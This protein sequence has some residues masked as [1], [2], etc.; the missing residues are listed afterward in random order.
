LEKRREGSYPKSSP[1]G[2]KDEVRHKNLFFKG[3]ECGEKE[4]DPYYLINHLES[5]LPGPRGNIL[6]THARVIGKE[7][8]KAGLISNARRKVNHA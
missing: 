5:S 2:K 3:R 4:E 1:E 6:K 7:E 8:G